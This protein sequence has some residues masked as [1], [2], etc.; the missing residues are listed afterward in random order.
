M[1]LVTED[2]ERTHQG[3]DNKPCKKLGFSLG[4]K[5]GKANRPSSSP[6]S[7]FFCVPGTGL[8]TED[9]VAVQKDNLPALKD[10]IYL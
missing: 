5:A 2:K 1:I 7:S 6:L 3:I 4:G 8:S 10:S 9:M